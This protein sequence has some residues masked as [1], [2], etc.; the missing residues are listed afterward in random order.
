MLAVFSLLFF[1]LIYRHLN[2]GIYLIL[3]CLPAYGVRFTVFSF[4]ATL[5]ELMILLLFFAWVLQAW[6]K[7]RLWPNTKFLPS[8]LLILVLSAVAVFVSP[9]L[10]RAAGIWKAY[11]AEAFLFFI[12]FVGVVKS[13]AEVKNIILALGAPVLYISV[14]GIVQA[15]TNG[16]LVPAEFWL[17]GD[18]HRVTSFFSY[19]NAIGLLVAPIVMLYLGYAWQWVKNSSQRWQIWLAL[20]SAAVIVGGGLVIWLAKSEGALVALAVG[21]LV[22]LVF[23]SSRTRWVAF[24]LVALGVG[25][26]ILNY[27]PELLIQKLT[28]HDWSGLVRLNMWRETIAM[29][30][31]HWFWG[32]GLAG[33]QTVVAPYHSSKAIEIF[34]FPHNIILNFWSELGLLG[35]LA[36]T[37]LTARYFIV[38]RRFLVSREPA[39][40][41]ALALA[42]AAV[43]VVVLTHGLVDAPYFK[44]DLAILWW[45]FFGLMSA[46]NNS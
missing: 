1:F 41:K 16:W 45:T 15:L 28:L 22:L 35:L 10:T 13:R 17:R 36:F 24:L 39:E 5:L 6:H 12:V 8:A 46:L 31:D 38:A 2:W 7:P 3:I 18:T 23:H 4:P 37:Y 27:L 44:N 32:A 29:L 14:F 42:M 30:R 21:V 25:C 20:Y 43:L 40:F 33:Y 19:P 26:L 9:D 34:L 11:F